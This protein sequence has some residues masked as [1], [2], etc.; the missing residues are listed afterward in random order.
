MRTLTRFDERTSKALALTTLLLLSMT[1][2]AQNKVSISKAVALPTKENPNHWQ[3]L[4][5]FSA[6]FDVPVSISQVEDPG[7]CPIKNPRNFYLFDVDFGQKLSIIYSYLDTG[8]FY[9]PA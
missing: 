7:K 4:V 1:C 6:G 8:A 3:I 9:T 5:G 2:L